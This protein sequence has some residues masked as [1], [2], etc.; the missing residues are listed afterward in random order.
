[1]SDA[2]NTAERAKDERDLAMLSLWEQ[3]LSAGQIGREFNVTRNI[4]LAQIWRVHQA[5]PTALDRKPTRT[6]R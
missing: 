3:G 4:P 2:S 5:D 1:M 6:P